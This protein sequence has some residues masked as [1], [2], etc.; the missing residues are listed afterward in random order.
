MTVKKASYFKEIVEGLNKRLQDEN[1]WLD[2]GQDSMYEPITTY[3]FPRDIR[4]WVDPFPTDANPK[5]DH[6]YSAL[7]Y[8]KSLGYTE[9]LWSLSEHH[10][11]Y[12]TCDVLDAMMIPIRSIIDNAKYTPPS[13]I[14][15]ISHPGCAC[16]LIVTG[17]ATPDG[18][19]DDAPGLPIHGEP[20]DLKRY[21]DMMFPNL[22]PIDVDSMTFPPA[23]THYSML[24]QARKKF[25]AESW[26]YKI[27]PVITA[28][29]FNAMLP[30]GFFRPTTS[31]LKGYQLEDDGTFSR[32]YLSDLNRV[33]VIPN[34]CLNFVDV[35]PQETGSEPGSFIVTSDVGDDTVGIIHRQR[36]DGATL[37][38]LPE[39]RS[40]VLVKNYTTFQ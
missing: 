9:C 4:D 5:D 7:E 36:E 29:N 11:K 23:T 6:S 1:R 2:L 8:L 20:E 15:S 26:E 18:I 30:L 25:S 33:I 14:F 22:L 32:V 13:P 27:Q 40:V 10:P 37:A 38:Y 21:K 24:F 3:A 34:E 28:M 16:Y 19:P 39:F 35:Q 17:P 12:D 31:G